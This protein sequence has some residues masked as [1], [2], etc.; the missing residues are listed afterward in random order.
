MDEERFEHWC[1]AR[2]TTAILTCEEAF[3]AGWDS[4]PRMGAWGVVSPRTCGDCGIEQTL[5]WALT[6][7]KKSIDDCAPQQRQLLARILN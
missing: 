1:E 4:P 7:E 3:E 5:W 6:V 2:D